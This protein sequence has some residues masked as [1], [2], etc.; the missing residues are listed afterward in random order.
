MF[1]L[2]AR[3]I[4]FVKNRPI[5]YKYLSKS[6]SKQDFKYL[7]KSK[8]TLRKFY[9]SKSKKVFLKN[10]TFKVKSKSTESCFCSSV[11]VSWEAIIVQGSCSPNVVVGQLLVAALPLLSLS[12]AGY[13]NSNNYRGP[14]DPGRF[15]LKLNSL[16]SYRCNERSITK[17]HTAS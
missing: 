15:L 1:I 2:R 16:I 5:W 7:S 9:L 10:N 14:S 11:V 6:K 13:I 3:L 17:T 8:S 4:S 12:L